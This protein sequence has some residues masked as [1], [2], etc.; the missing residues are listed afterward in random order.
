[1]LRGRGDSLAK[2]LAHGAG[3]QRASDSS[4]L[5]STQPVMAQAG[6]DES[7][8]AGQVV[9]PACPIAAS[10]LLACFIATH[11]KRPPFGGLGAATTVEST[12]LLHHS[13]PIM[14]KPTT[15]QSPAGRW[16]PIVR[17]AGHPLLL[18][19]VLLSMAIT[20]GKLLYAASWSESRCSASQSRYSASV[21]LP[22]WQLHRGQ[23][24]TMLAMAFLPPRVSGVTWSGTSSS[25]GSWRP[26]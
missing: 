9:F 20:G 7:L 26:Q 3:V 8:P 14:A 15:C 5:W 13:C 4:R 19:N 25:G 23:A 17:Q 10:I 18:G 21:L 16:S 2:R 22:F 6:G 11:L 12:P 1:M 24:G